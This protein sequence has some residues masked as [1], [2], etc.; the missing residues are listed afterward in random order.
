MHYANNGQRSPFNDTK[1]RL[2]C[3]E[4]YDYFYKDTNIS[5]CFRKDSPLTLSEI[6]NNSI[7]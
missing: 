4:I 1:A 2:Y 6:L 3:P 7:E 5:F